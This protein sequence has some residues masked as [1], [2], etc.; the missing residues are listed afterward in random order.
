[1]PKPSPEDLAEA[2]KLAAEINHHH[3]EAAK[4]ARQGLYHAI[5]A[6]RRL[7]SAKELVGH[8]NFTT[9]RKKSTTVGERMAQYYMEA[10]GYADQLNV[11]PATIADFTITG[12]IDWA[13]VQL[14]PKKQ[15]RSASAQL[16]ASGRRVKEDNESSNPI[17]IA[18]KRATTEKREQFHTFLVETYGLNVQPLT[19]QAA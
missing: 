9:W 15:R 18:Y 16:T 3:C 5:E 17:C 2:T 19:Q 4:A 7:K 14:E 8:G 10:A 1:M 11:E 13:K 6:G 12:F